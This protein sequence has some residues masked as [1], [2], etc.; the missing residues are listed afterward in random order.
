MLGNWFGT[1]AITTEASWCSA[2]RIAWHRMIGTKAIGLNR[3]AI[4]DKGRIVAMDTPDG[5]KASISSS[6]HAVIEGNTV[7]EGHTVTLEDVFMALT[8]KQLTEE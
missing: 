6:G 2:T 1:D 3:I 5:L 4:L 7:A 8:G